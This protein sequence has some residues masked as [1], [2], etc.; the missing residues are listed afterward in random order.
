[1]KEVLGGWLFNM[2]VV[3]HATKRITNKMFKD[4]KEWIFSKGMTFRH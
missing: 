3:S 4:I 1:V 2:R